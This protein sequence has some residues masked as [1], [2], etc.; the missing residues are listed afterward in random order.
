MTDSRK[1]LRKAAKRTNSH[2]AYL[3]HRDKLAFYIENNYLCKTRDKENI[4]QTMKTLLVR[5]IQWLTLLLS[6]LTL[7]PLF[8]YL[9][10]RWQLIGKKVR[11]FLLLIS[12]LMLIVYFIIFLLALQGYFDY[13]RKYRFADNEVIE[14]IT[15]IAFPEVDIIE[16]KK[17]NGGFLGDYND[18]LTLEM[19]DELSDY[20]DSII[21]AG[22]TQWSKHDDEYSYSII[23]GNGFLAPKGE[24]DEE[25]MMFSL[26]MKKGSKI[27]TLYSGSW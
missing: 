11:M 21:S 10:R 18:E 12:P 26:S 5:T 20:L 15:G 13:Q 22:N 23:W 8:F 9:A 3:P 7:S 14:R 17:D 4:Q 16:Y 19:E 24:D 2:K 1:A 27:V 6:W 25:D